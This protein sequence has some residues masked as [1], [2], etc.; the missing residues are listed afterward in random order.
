MPCKPT[1]VSSTK[2][3]F[4]NIARLSWNAS[5]GAIFYT[6]TVMTKGGQSYNCTSVSKQCAISTV[7]CGLNTSVTVVASN[8][9]CNSELSEVNML[10]SGE[11]LGFKFSLNLCFEKIACWKLTHATSLFKKNLAPC[12]P[13]DVKAT[14]NCSNNQAVVSWSASRG[15]LSYKVSAMST[16]GAQSTCE[17][18]LTRCV[19]TNLTCGQVYS[20]QVVAVDNVCSG[21]PSQPVQFKSGKVY[22]CRMMC[23][24]EWLC[25][26]SNSSMTSFSSLHTQNRL[27]GFGL[28][29]QHGP[30][31]LDVC[32]WG[33]EIHFNS[34][35]LQW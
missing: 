13:T 8:T 35:V 20:V 34:T 16:Q 9:I 25:L 27:C 7:P 26:I 30:F 3:C 28:R 24:H 6:A 12:I 15:A 22:W 11:V 4:T 21:L 33:P 1:N 2:N 10:Q 5:A 17:T 23:V 19:L 32:W 31:K 29:H 18:G 14:V